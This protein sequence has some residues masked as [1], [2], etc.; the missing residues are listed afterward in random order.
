VHITW[1]DYTDY[2]GSGTDTDIF[3][4]HWNATTATWTTTEVVSTESSNSSYR[5]P[6]LAAD[7]SGN[8]HI[9][10]GDDT[11]YGGSGTDIDIFYKYWNATTAT[12]TTTEVVSTESTGDSEAPTIAADGSG[13]VHIAWHDYTDYGSSGTDRDIFYKRFISS[14]PLNPSII[15]NN[16]D[17]STNSTLVDLTLSADGAEDMCFNNGTI[18][19]WT[20]W[21]PY[22]TTKQLYLEGSIN[23][24]QYSIYVK[25]RNAIGETTPVSDSILYLITAEKEEPAPIIPGYPDGWIIISLLAGIGVIAILNKSK[26]IKLRN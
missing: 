2:G 8:V 11:N 19:T 20:I 7:G 3:Y 9:T 18:G 21:E 6:T 13:N 22:S 26:K 4:K 14:S 12:W 25:F 1:Q 15:I 16:G 5:G 17:A 23:N 24:T 10:W